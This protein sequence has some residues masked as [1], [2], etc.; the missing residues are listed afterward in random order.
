M[1]MF[2]LYEISIN[3]FCVPISVED[4]GTVVLSS[5]VQMSLVFIPNEVLS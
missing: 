4:R 3:L 5:S 2:I 1:K